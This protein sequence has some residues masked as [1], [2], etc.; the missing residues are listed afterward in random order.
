[1][2]GR[3]L[4]RRPSR[5]AL[6]H[7]QGFPSVPPRVFRPTNSLERQEVNWASLSQNLTNLKHLRARGHGRIDRSGRGVLR[8]AR[9]AT[10]AGAP[11]PGLN[12]LPGAS[13]TPVILLDGGD[14]SQRQLACGLARALPE[15]LAREGVEL[16][17]RASERY[18]R[19]GGHP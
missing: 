3:P 6:P 1:M 7:P 8:A 2:R 18:R 5:P 14:E 19:S 17:I 15:N 13:Q 9:L 16:L 4:P 11:P 10:R 12:G